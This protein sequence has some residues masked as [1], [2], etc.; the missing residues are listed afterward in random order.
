MPRQGMDILG[1]FIPGGTIVGSNAWVLQRRPEIF[2][3]DVDEFRPERWLEAS[4]SQLSQMKAMMFQFGAGARTCLGK[5]ISTLEMFVEA[6]CHIHS[7]NMLTMEF[8]L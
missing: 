6:I 5:N 8:H 3:E 2:G 4:S 1:N 7:R